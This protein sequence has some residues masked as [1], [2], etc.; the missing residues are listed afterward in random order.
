M[1]NKLYM[2]KFSSPML[3]EDLHNTVTCCGTVRPKREGMTKSFGQTTELQP[4]EHCGMQR[5]T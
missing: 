5:Q 3:F 2:V 1:R 4:G